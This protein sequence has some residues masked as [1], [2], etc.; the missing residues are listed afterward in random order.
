MITRTGVRR[1]REL[2]GRVDEE[3]SAEVLGVQ[4]R[5]NGLDDGGEAA[6]GESAAWIRSSS[7]SRSV[8]DAERR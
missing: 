7:A 1:V 6:W 5:V 2:G 4:R 3:R 8:S